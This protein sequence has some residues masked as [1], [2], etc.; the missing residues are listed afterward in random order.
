MAPVQ[1]L[2]RELE[3]LGQSLLYGMGLLAGYDVLRIFRR[4]FPHGILWISAEDI[5][6]WLLAGGFFFLKLCQA[7]NGIIRG[8]I[9]LGILLGAWSYYYFCSRRMMRILT[10]AVIRVKK[11]LK[12]WHNMITMKTEKIRNHRKQ[13]EVRKA[14]E[15]YENEE[16]KTP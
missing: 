1:G 3:L 11:Q 13:A 8:Y 9:L 7:N 14:G 2:G 4:L 15:E 16:K 6:Y 12:K 10:K 5:F